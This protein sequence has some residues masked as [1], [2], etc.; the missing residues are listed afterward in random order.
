MELNPIGVSDFTSAIEMSFKL[1]I[2]YGGNSVTV[3]GTTDFSEPY[4]WLP[5]NAEEVGVIAD[6]VIA[7]GYP[8][9]TLRIRS[10]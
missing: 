2:S 7:A 1:T 10:S 4:E 5:T 6:A 9:V 8:D 3:T